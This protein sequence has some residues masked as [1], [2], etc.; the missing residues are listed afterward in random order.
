MKKISRRN[1]L[2]AAGVS[3]AALGLTACG[4]SSSSTA[5]PASSAAG[6]PA[7]A[8]GWKKGDTVTIHVPAKAGGGSDLYTRYLTAALGEV[9][10]GVNFVVNNYDTGEV[11]MEACKNGDPDGLTLGMNHGGG[12]IQW[13]T[14][15]SNVSMKDDVKVI[16]VIT[17]GGP[18]AIIANP[19]AP[20]KNFKEFADYLKANPGET[21]IGCSL[22][23]T[24]QMI[25]VSLVDALTGNSEDALYVQCS[26]EADKLTQTASG[27]I[28]IANC[29]L[30]NALQYQADGKLTIIGTIGPKMSTID[31]MEKLM[32]I[33][34]NDSFK[35]GPEQG[36]DSATWDSAYYL[37]APKDTPDEVCKAINE[38][39]NKATDVASYQEGMKAMAGFY[40]KL[41]Y[42]EVTAVFQAEWEFMDNLTA[43][44]GLKAR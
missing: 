36:I 41:D 16:G 9:C 39:V 10:P 33:E 34:L 22:G 23:G 42:D 44:M 3:A 6:A 11:G 2:L 38:A 7:A 15:A 26:S 31:E 40:D 43:D 28:N 27:A 20:Y 21:V 13:L 19:D 29:S 37:F 25:F 4:G 17:L 30:P 5:A 18:Q 8:P 35:S 32:G 1:F 14:G 24:T 12:I